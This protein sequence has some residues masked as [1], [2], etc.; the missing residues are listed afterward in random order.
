MKK[1]I[2]FPSFLLSMIMTIMGGEQNEALAQ[3]ILPTADWYAVAWVRDTDTLHSSRLARIPTYSHDCYKVLIGV[4]MKVHSPPMVESVGNRNHGA[5]RAFGDVYPKPAPIFV[6]SYFWNTLT[7]L[8]RKDV[9][10]AAG[11]LAWRNAVAMAWY[12]CG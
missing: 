5:E 6:R 1:R 12:W 8:Y 10:H 9:S 7:Q 4:E 11:F 3:T 2:N